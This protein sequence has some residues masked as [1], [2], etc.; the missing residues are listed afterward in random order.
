MENVEK[1]LENSG[2]TGKPP[3]R[4]RPARCLTCSNEWTAR[5]G[6]EEKPSRCP[7]CGS[8]NVKWRDECDAGELGKDGNAMENMENQFSG[9]ENG[10]GKVEL[11]LENVEN[12]T[13]KLENGEKLL[14][15]KPTIKTP[16]IP[17]VENIGKDGMEKV[18]LEEIQKNFTGIPVFPLIWIMGIIGVFGLIWFLVG[19]AKKRREAR[20]RTVAE[21]QTPT[22]PTDER[23]RLRLAGGVI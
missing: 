4:D 7:V 6:N 14:E 9:V 22:N 15:P 13:G 16:V 2:K 21:S 23:I 20:R 12:G 10:G 5:N 8:R 18:T 3:R 1:P 11:P 17:P 19:Q